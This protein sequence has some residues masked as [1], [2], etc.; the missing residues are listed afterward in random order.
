MCD[1]RKNL[2]P[3]VEDFMAVYPSTNPSMSANRNEG[4]LWLSASCGASTNASTCC[5]LRIRFN[6]RALATNIS[7]SG[8]ASGTALK[9]LFWEESMPSYGS[10]A[11]AF[12]SCSLIPP[13]NASNKQ[14]RKSV[15]RGSLGWRPSSVKGRV[16][17]LAGNEHDGPR[18]QISD[19]GV[20]SEWVYSGMTEVLPQRSQLD[21]N[22]YVVNVAITLSTACFHPPQLFAVL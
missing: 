2:G 4:T 17:L 6:V 12:V 9:Q 7:A 18:L 13:K 3:T 10:V 21:F 1:L 5:A 22:V 8:N 20:S 15:R 19:E 14:K 11:A 16:P